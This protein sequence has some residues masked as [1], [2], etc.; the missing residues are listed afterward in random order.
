M[1]LTNDIFT[2]MNRE[3]W[4]SNPVSVRLETLTQLLNFLIIKIC[5]QHA[6]MDI[7][8]EHLNLESESPL[9]NPNKQAD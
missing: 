2:P 7:Y 4:Y 3:A 5:P 1:F 8:A 9:D 6:S